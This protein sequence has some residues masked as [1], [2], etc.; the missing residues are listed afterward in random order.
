MQNDLDKEYK[1]KIQKIKELNTTQLR[2]NNYEAILKIHFENNVTLKKLS[3]DCDISYEALTYAKRKARKDVTGFFFGKS[4]RYDVRSK[5]LA[6]KEVQAG[7]LP[8]DIAQKY[9][10]SVA[11]IYNWMRKYSKN[12]EELLDMPDGVPFIV[13]TENHIYGLRNIVDA[14]EQL[15]ESIRHLELI[16]TLAEE[17][18]IDLGKMTKAKIKKQKKMSEDKRNTLKE[19]MDIVKENKSFKA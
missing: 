14:I 3:K 5:V 18:K 2:E 16:E 10:V 8:Q 11:T 9:N 6:V 1:K 12:Q 15:E 19:A 4:I 17:E 7:A 13:D